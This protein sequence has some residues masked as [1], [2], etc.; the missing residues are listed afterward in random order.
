MYRELVSIDYNTNINDEISKYLNTIDLSNLL[1]GNINLSSATIGYLGITGSDIKSYSNKFNLNSDEINLN[2]QSINFFGNLNINTN[3]INQLVFEIKSNNLTI[4]D[5]LIEICQNPNDLINNRGFV[6]P[7]YSGIN[8]INKNNGFIGFDTTSKT[9]KLINNIIYDKITNV[10]IFPS[11]TSYGTLELYNLKIENINAHNNQLNINSNNVSLSNNINITNQLNTKYLSL[12]NNTLCNSNDDSNIYLNNNQIL[13]NNSY[14]DIKD[15][16]ITDQYFQFN[17]DLVYTFNKI[18]FYN[19]LLFTQNINLNNNLYIQNCPDPINPFDL[20]NKNYV[21]NNKLFGNNVVN[22]IDKTWKIFNGVSDLNNMILG[23]S[24]I[25]NTVYIK[26]GIPDGTQ[27]TLTDNDVI[28]MSHSE[29]VALIDSN[30]QFNTLSDINQ[31]HSIRKKNNK[32]YLERIKKL[33][34]YSYCY[35]NKNN[36]HLNNEIY[37]GIIQQDIEKIFN[38]NCL[39]KKKINKNH[40]CNI[41]CYNNNDNNKFV[42]YNEILCYTILA[43]KE[44]INITDD[45]IMLINNNLNKL[46][47]INYYFKIIIFINIVFLIIIICYINYLIS[48]K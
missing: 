19:E 37:V 3:N 33:N 39:N 15:L 41:N 26:K 6:F 17:N 23:I 47:Y 4:N 14:I 5:V 10:S 46:E 40:I 29:N 35:K 42:N 44:Y 2:G 13:T 25:Y 48:L 45:K 31:K 28:F 27:I 8:N 12:N 32:N 11:Y 38:G 20:C 36:D 16:L 21:D 34:I 1:G 18:K 22:T 9:F 24:D 43:I 30:G 7:W